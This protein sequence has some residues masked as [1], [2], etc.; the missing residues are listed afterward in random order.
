MGIEAVSDLL[1]DTIWMSLVISAPI[2]ATALATGLVISIF[3][4]ATQVNEQ[5][6][7]FVPKIVLT[8]VAFGAGFPYF[9]TTLVEFTRRIFEA[10]AGTAP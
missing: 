4:A 2:L 7:T 6:L 8:L 1:R 3:Q 10:A 9:M 5:T